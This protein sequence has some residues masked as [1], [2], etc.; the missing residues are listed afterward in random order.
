MEG[1]KDGRTEVRKF[2]PVSYRTS[3][4]WGRCPK[5]SIDDYDEEQVKREEGD[6]EEEEE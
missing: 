1:W 6:D 5:R 3:A 4:L 2:T